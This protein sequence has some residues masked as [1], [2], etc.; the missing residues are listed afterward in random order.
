MSFTLFRR[1]WQQLF[2]NPQRFFRTTSG[3]FIIIVDSLTPEY[4]S[5]DS[6]F[7]YLTDPEF[8]ALILLARETIRHVEPKP[9]N[10]AAPNAPTV[11]PRVYSNISAPTYESTST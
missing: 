3:R 7:L 9:S 5:T 2:T 8:R 10:Y 6:S 11:Q 1:H 4:D